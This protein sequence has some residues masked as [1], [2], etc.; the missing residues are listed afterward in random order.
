[1]AKAAWMV[2]QAAF[3]IRSWIVARVEAYCQSVCR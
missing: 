1:M 3:A 2:F